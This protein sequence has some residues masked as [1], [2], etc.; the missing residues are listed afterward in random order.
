MMTRTEEQAEFWMLTKGILQDE[1][2][3]TDEAHVVLR[4]V[5]E[6]NR[7]GEFTALIEELRKYLSDNWI[8]RFESKQIVT[9]IGN[10]LAK[11]RQLKQAEA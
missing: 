6:H 4:W 1:R 3:E 10:V 2:V 9:V 8:D 7:A 5:E 11:L